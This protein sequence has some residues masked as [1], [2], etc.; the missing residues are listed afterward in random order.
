MDKKRAIIIAVIVIILIIVLLALR[1][2]AGKKKAPGTGEV[3]EA[4]PPAGEK[5][6]T[7]EVKKKVSK[8]DKQL[9]AYEFKKIKKA[10]DKMALEVKK[11]GKVIMTKETAAKEKLFINI[12][13]EDKTLP[14]AGAD[15]NGDNRPDMVV[16]VRSEKDSC[17]NAYSVF[18]VFDDMK[19][20]AEIKGL[21]AGMEVKDI[22]GDKVPE[23][24]GRDCTFL[25]WWASFGETPAPKVV[26]R[27]GDG[28]YVFAEDVM[29]KDAPERQEMQAYINKNKGKF[30]SYVWKYMLDLIYT[31]NGSKAWEF[32]E[33]VPFDTEWEEQIMDD[34]SKKGIG[35]KEEYLGAFKEHLATSPYYEDIK[36]FNNWEMLDVEM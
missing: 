33:M 13:G 28:R 17:S 24:I 22:D 31:G 27:W 8:K 9:E 19:L 14:K 26:L 23:I 2:S 12:E 32:Y 7:P 34:E 29:R 5:A 20:L 3:P 10:G 11:N 16:Q 4:T 25:D 21:A 18:S 36:Y 1:C 35:S 30:I 15:M 6:A